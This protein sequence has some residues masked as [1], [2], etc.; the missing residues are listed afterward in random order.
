MSECSSFTGLRQ[1]LCS[2]V[3][4]SSAPPSIKQGIKY[5]DP[6]SAKG[7]PAFSN[8]MGLKAEEILDPLDSFS[9]FL[10]LPSIL[11]SLLNPQFL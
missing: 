3:C 6:E 7:I 10:C 2:L 5:D 11:L 4:S 1:C 9:A 8:S